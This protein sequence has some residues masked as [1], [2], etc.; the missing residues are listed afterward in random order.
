[1]NTRPEYDIPYYSNRDAKTR[2]AAERILQILFESVRPSSLID[3]GCGVGTWA[4]V[5][6]ELGVDHYLCV[7]GPWVDRETL[8]VPES[9]FRSVDIEDISSIEGKWELS[10]C[11]EV[12]EHLSESAGDR[13]IH[14]V[15][16]HSDLA[17]FSAAIP[18]QMGRGHKNEQ[19]QSYWVQRFN[20]LEFYSIDLI[21][22]KI[23]G[24]PDI[25]YWYKQNTILYI[26]KSCEHFTEQSTTPHESFAALNVVHPV[27]WTKQRERYLKLL[28]EKRTKAGVKKSFRDLMLALA[29]KLRV[30]GKN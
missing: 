16:A 23:W 3:I 5:A 25:P 22:P 30:G 12:A 8:V 21:R 26:S 19:W 1:M 29:R 20:S 2:F 10:I 14:W 17:L 9:R 27:L 15:C 11:L 4:A 24:D 13:L 7:D 6:S 28:T 18:G